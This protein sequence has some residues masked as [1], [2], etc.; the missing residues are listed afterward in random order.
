MDQVKIQALLELKNLKEAQII[1]E[2]EFAIFKDKILADNISTQN[3]NPQSD[4]EVTIKAENKNVNTS[5]F[6]LILIGVLAFI[7]ILFLI[8][9]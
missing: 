2:A 5:S 6:Y 3:D 1:N 7:A 8:E 4:N 9:N